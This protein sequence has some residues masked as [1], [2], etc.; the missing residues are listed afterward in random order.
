MTGVQTCA[1]PILHK[2]GGTKSVPK[3]EEPEPVNLTSVYRASSVAH[4]LPVAAHPAYNQ[5]YAN[6]YQHNIFGTMTPGAPRKN[7]SK[8]V[9]SALVHPGAAPVSTA[10]VAS[11]TTGLFSLSGS[12]GPSLFTPRPKRSPPPVPI[13]PQN[14]TRSKGSA[15]TRQV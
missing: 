6:H 12:Y 15:V 5:Y 1:L 4:G 11:P 2:I 7:G 13:S 14:K 10:S 9:A 3:F 8:S